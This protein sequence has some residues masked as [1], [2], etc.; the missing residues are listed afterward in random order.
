MSIPNNYTVLSNFL[1]NIL[2]FEVLHDNIRAIL[3]KSGFS[4]TLDLSVFHSAR[5][6]AMELSK[7]P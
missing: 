4:K 6:R 1:N 2:N 3:S 5:D 7:F